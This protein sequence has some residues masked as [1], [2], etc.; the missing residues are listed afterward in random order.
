V[1]TFEVT[2]HYEVLNAKY[3]PAHNADP[4]NLERFK[5]IHEAYE[6]LKAAPCRNQYNKFGS[7]VRAGQGEGQDPISKTDWRLATSLVFYIT[8]ALLSTSLSSVEV[9]IILNPYS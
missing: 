6:C 5:K 7:F 4:A 9:S 3:N 1:G 2:E 8:Y